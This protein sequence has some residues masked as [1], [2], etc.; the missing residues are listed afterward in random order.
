VNRER[1][2]LHRECSLADGHRPPCVRLNPS[3]KREAQRRARGTAGE[4]PAAWFP[5]LAQNDP[6]LLAQLKKK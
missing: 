4:W 6:E 2:P 3:A 1:C 5:K